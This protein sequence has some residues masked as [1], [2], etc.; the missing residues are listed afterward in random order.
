MKIERYCVAK[1]VPRIYEGNGI[2][3]VDITDKKETDLF[4]EHLYHMVHPQ[5]TAKIIDEFIVKA[6]SSRNKN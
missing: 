3:V 6:E 5:Q 4:R 1:F 2:E